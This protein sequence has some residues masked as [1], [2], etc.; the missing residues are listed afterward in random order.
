MASRASSP[1]T[2]WISWC[3][4]LIRVPRNDLTLTP[5]QSRHPE[6]SLYLRLKTTNH[7]PPSTPS[8]SSVLLCDSAFTKRTETTK[9]AWQFEQWLE[10]RAAEEREKRGTD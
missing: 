3:R 1:S 5:D 4:S 10:E 6:N 8:S 9:R 2:T 7:A